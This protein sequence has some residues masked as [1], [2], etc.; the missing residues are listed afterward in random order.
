MMSMD[1]V[2]QLREE[3]KRLKQE[4]QELRERLMAAEATINRAIPK[5]GN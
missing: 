3:I 5:S 4:N 2:Q 1:E